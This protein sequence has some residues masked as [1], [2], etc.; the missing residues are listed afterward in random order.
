MF[1]RHT[2]TDPII[3]FS[4]CSS[5]I[6]EKQNS[7]KRDYIKQCWKWNFLRQQAKE[8]NLLQ[9]CAF[10]FVYCWF[11]WNKVV[12]SVYDNLVES[13]MQPVK[14]NIRQQLW[15][16]SSCDGSK[17]RWDALAILRSWWIYEKFAMQYFRLATTA[18]CAKGNECINFLFYLN[19][20]EENNATTCTK[21]TWTHGKFAH[22]IF[23]FF[24]SF[25]YFGFDPML[26]AAFVC[27]HL[28]SKLWLM[29]K[30]IIQFK[31]LFHNDEF[32][33][34]LQ[35]AASLKDKRDDSSNDI[36]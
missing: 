31:T 14:W 13:A 1:V 20:D 26:F 24:I 2:C 35:C 25:F 3:Y 7:R 36:V 30:K 5:F 17:L 33:F 8:S 12:E 19:E 23:F 28:A 34:F 15:A 29:H 10:R 32:F 4:K 21:S 27:F 6:Q 16:V 9:C 11:Q 18:L 22:L